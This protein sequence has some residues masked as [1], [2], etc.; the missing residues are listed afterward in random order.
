[1]RYFKQLVAR[2]IMLYSCNILTTDMSSVQ[3]WSGVC[4]I[5]QQL[6]FL[7]EQNLNLL[8]NLPTCLCCMALHQTW[9]C[10]R[11]IYS[12]KC[13]PL[14]ICIKQYQ[15]SH[16]SRKAPR[17]CMLGYCHFFDS[18]AYTVK[19]LL[20]VPKFHN[21]SDFSED[22]VSLNHCHVHIYHLIQE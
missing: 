5:C 10:F 14:Q 19:L 13:R 9:Q 2:K 21:T 11:L 1:M 17:H 3:F 20:L 4:C 12:G 22:T 7:R 6:V 16:N 18:D 15:N 8:M